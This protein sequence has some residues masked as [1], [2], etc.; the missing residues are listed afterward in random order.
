MKRVIVLLL[1]LAIVVSFSGCGTQDNIDTLSSVPTESIAPTETP[2]YESTPVETAPVETAPETVPV[3]LKRYPL[4][5]DR[6]YVNL[7]QELPAHIYSTT[8]SENGLGGTVYAFS[9]IV[10]DYFSFTESGIVFENIVVK[11]DGGSV[12]ITNHYKAAYNNSMLLIGAD[13]TKALYPYNIDYYVFPEVGQAASFVAI[14]IGYSGVEEL[15]AFVLGANPSI[16]EM[17][18]YD[19]PATAIDSTEPTVHQ[20]GVFGDKLILGNLELSI[21]DDFII[22]I[23][24]DNT[25]SLASSDKECVF[26]LHATDISQLSKAQTIEYLPMQHDAFMTEGIVRVNE[27]DLDGIVAGFDLIIDFYGEM[28]ENLDIKTC[29]DTSFTDSWYAYTIMFKCNPN[30]D[31]ANE[32]VKTFIDFI[33]YSKYLGDTPRFDYVQ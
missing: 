33:S 19:D 27:S 4:N 24:D 15:P 5:I 28:S 10:E 14:Y 7:A 6:V 22:T 29:M 17:L 18:E 16:F 30:T 21:P 8:G 12:L 20:T 3:E 9:G 13:L 25:F 11:T 26:A 32:Y 1:T 2:L 31:R 23:V